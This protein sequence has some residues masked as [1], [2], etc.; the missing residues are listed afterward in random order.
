MGLI[1]RKHVFVVNNQVGL[2]LACS[3]SNASKKKLDMPYIDTEVS[4]LSRE[5]AKMCCF[6]V[7]V[8]EKADLHLCCLHKAGFLMTWLKSCSVGPFQCLIN[9][10]LS[11]EELCYVSE[12]YFVSATCIPSE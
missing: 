3:T 8:D 10:L 11:K 2:G 7:C 6:I 5:Q 9:V 4:K 1:I 12:M